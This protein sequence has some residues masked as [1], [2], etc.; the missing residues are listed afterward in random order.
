MLTNA[1]FQSTFP[2]GTDVTR[3]DCHHILLAL[4]LTRERECVRDPCLAEHWQSKVEF[5]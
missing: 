5:S 4:T 2:D 3:L 1:H